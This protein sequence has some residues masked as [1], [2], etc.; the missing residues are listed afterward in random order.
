MARITRFF[1]SALAVL[2][3]LIGT[4]GVAAA[5]ERSP[6]PPPPANYAA[7]EQLYRLRQAQ[8]RSLDEMLKRDAHRI[9]EIEKLIA[10]AKAHGLNTTALEHALATYR[11]ML[12][13]ARTAWQTAADALKTHAGFSDAGKVINLDRARATLKTAE[14]GLYTSYRT[15][16]S[17]EQL[18]NKALAVFRNRK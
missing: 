6:T 2:L 13:N 16:Q 12:R 10:Y 9:T 14:N 3:V 8:V 4:F 18:L 7:L 11:S 15:A 17:A 1:F 5:E